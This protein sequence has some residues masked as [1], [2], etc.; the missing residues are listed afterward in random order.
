MCKNNVVKRS[1]QLLFDLQ[2]DLKTYKDVHLKT[3]KGEY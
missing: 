2:I 1:Y 3:E